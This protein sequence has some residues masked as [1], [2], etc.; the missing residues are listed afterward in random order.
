MTTN[1][2]VSLLHLFHLSFNFYRIHT[3]AKLE[4]LYEIAAA[5]NVE[6][7]NIILDAGADIND[8]DVSSASCYKI[9]LR[10]PPFGFSPMEKVQRGAAYSDYLM[11]LDRLSQIPHPDDCRFLENVLRYPCQASFIQNI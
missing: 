2:N 9:A 7:L 6:G 11:A 1:R 10:V 3:D 4:P 5:G 8:D